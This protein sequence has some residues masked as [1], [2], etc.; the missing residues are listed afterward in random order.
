MN[1]AF[2]IF[3]YLGQNKYIEG[4]KSIKASDDGLSSILCWWKL[5]RVKFD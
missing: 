2:I 4:N 3:V 1:F 5:I